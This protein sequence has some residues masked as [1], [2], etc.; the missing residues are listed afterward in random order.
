MLIVDHLSGPQIYK[1]TESRSFEAI[2]HEDVQETTLEIRLRL[3]K[4]L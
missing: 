4:A 2:G 1:G 3:S